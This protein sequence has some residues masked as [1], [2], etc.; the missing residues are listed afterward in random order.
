ML[1][2]DSFVG[3][4][5]RKEVYDQSVGL[6]ITLHIRGIRISKGKTRRR[7]GIDRL[8]PLEV[9]AIREKD[10]PLCSNL[11][12][13]YKEIRGSFENG[14][15]PGRRARRRNQKYLGS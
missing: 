5:Q 6:E 3:G 12:D 15:N 1:K 4:Q 7:V 13:L 8:S 14:G 9:Q 11:E 10:G 2:V